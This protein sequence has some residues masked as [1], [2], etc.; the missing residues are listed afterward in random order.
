M[1]T[2]Q[3]IKDDYAKE[4]SY[5]DWEDVLKHDEGSLYIDEIARRYAIACCKATQKNINEKTRGHHTFDE[6]TENIL[7]PD[8]IVIL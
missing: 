8:N 4:R 2:L 1:Q 7:N 5:E 6:L 3:Q